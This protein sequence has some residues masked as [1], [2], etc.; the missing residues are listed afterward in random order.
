[1]NDPSESPPTVEKEPLDDMGSNTWYWAFLRIFFGTIFK[2]YFRGE[3][4]GAENIPK[5]GGYIIVANHVSNLDPLLIPPTISRYIYMMAKAELRDAFLTR[6][7]L[8][9]TNAVPIRREGVDRN[10]LRVGTRLVKEGHLLL[11]FAEGTRAEDG[12]L[13]KAKPG[14]SMMA[15]QA[16]CPCIPLYIDG[17]FPLLS[18]KMLFPRPGKVKIIFGKP[19][20][21][22][23]R[24]KGVASRDHF[25]KCGNEIMSQIAAL[26]D[27]LSE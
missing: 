23:Q 7:L 12:Q 24:E 3:I 1:M 13:Q 22:P 10:A 8:P 19:F 4:H 11:V 6:L 26:R 16:K 14:V 25:E 21:L 20:D 27:G 2:I 9:W 15:V 5:H 17:T 18:R